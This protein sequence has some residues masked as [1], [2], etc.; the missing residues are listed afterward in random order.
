MRKYVACRQ[1]L[2]EFIKQLECCWEL[3]RY[4]ELCAH[5]KTLDSELVLPTPFKLLEK[6]TTSIYTREVFEIVQSLCICALAFVSREKFH[7]IR[8]KELSAWKK[9]DEPS[10]YCTCVDIEDDGG[11]DD[12]DEDSEFV[13]DNSVDHYDAMEDMGESD[14][15]DDGARE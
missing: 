9:S 8:D 7:N 4:N 6:S 11:T 2:C 12:D 3:I 5:Y 15:W 14:R 10:E 1:N 13:D